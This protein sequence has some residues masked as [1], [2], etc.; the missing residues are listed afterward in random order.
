MIRHATG[1]KPANAL[2]A[3]LPGAGGEQAHEGQAAHAC[4]V[5][6]RAVAA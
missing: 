4:H 6:R 2:R 3:D 5:I 1:Y